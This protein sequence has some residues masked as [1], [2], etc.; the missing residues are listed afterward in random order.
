MLVLALSVG[1]VLVVSAFCSLSEASLYAVRRPYVRGLVAEG[2]RS[3][4]ILDE[5]KNNMDQ[6]IAA[7]LVVNTLANTA[8]AAVAGAQA[9]AI[10]GGE[11]VV[12][13]SGIFTLLV[14]CFSEIIPKVLGVVH[15]RPIAKAV[16]LP[17][18]VL[19]VLLTPITYLVGRVSQ[20]LKPNEPILAA[21]EEEVRAFAQLSAE[22]GSILELEASLV[23]NVLKL[24]EV[25]A[26]DIMTPRRVV[27]RLSEDTRL[28]Q[29]RDN[30]G[31]WQFS[32]IPVHHPDDSEKWTGVVRAADVLVALAQGRGD[33]VLKDLSSPLHFVPDSIA[34]HELLQR[35]LK[36]RTHLFGVVDEFGGVGGV[37]SL[38]DV[39][40]T[41]LGE[42]IVDEVDRADDLRELARTKYGRRAQPD[43]PGDPNP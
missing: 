13:F 8:G 24:N 42:E 19:I 25:A 26:R 3:G 4:K 41:L 11:A 33:T 1:A 35:F 14:L 16:A 6:P 21:S 22:E 31:D 43:L 15:N 9:A 18:S 28:D 5:F 36:E 17:W 40:E 27:F 12:W 23:T 37:A 34:A 2:N 38:E 7:I 30:V 39:L 10:F 20:W 32:R 29:L